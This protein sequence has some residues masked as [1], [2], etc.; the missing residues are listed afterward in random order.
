ML[1]VPA[2]P[3]PGATLRDDDVM[4]ILVAGAHGRVGSRVTALLLGRGHVV[5]ALV[6]TRAQADA[7]ES[8][9]AQAVL[10]DLRG[11]VEW[12]A[13][14]CDAAVFAAGARHRSELP[15]IDAGG[16]AK[17]AEAADRYEL[18][19]FV[20]CSAVGAARPDRREGPLRE[21]L[22]A[23][24]GAE[25]RVERLDMSWTIVRFG[26]LTEAP[27]SGRISTSVPAGTPVTLNRD[28]AALALVEA[29]AREQ[30]GHQ[31]VHVIDG[32]RLVADALDAIEPR[33]LPAVHNSGL[34]AAQSDNPP[35]DPDMLRPD[36]SPLDT[37]VDFE[38][39][40]PLPPELLGNEDPSPGVP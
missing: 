11:D 3:P 36:A 35:D 22:S 9:G 40:G 30:L 19:R 32:E 27:G 1:R 33:P 31:V 2:S 39:D 21:F 17:L 29:L 16:A 34:G 25:R 12:T 24:H 14:G 15:A 37:D 20:M 13:D 10:A 26:R 8:V 28:D 5:R 7:L 23:K 6:R 38:G 4:I 18:R